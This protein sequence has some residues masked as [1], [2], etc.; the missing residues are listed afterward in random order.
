MFKIKV[1]ENLKRPVSKTSNTGL[2][3]HKVIFTKSHDYFI[4]DTLLDPQD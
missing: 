4:I 1:I 3:N 2:D